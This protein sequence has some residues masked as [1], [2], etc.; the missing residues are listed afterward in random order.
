MTRKLK[1]SFM[2][3]G[4][5]LMFLVLG[6]RGWAQTVRL[7]LKKT[8]LSKVVAALQQQAPTVNFTFSQEVLE[9]VKVDHIQLK[10]GSLK[11]ALDVLEKQYGLHY[12]LDGTNLTLKYVPL[13]ATTEA[14]MAGGRKIDGFVADENGQ[15]VRAATVHLKG[16]QNAVVTDD[17]G[18]YS[19]TVMAGEHLEVS[20][21]G[22]GTQD[23]LVKGVSPLNIRMHQGR[24]ALNE[25]VFVGY[26]KM[27]KSDFTGAVASVKAS[28]LNVSAPTV[29]QG[30]VGKVAG[31]VVSQTDGSPYASPKIR[32]RGVNSFNAAT[33]PL[34]VIDGYPAGNDIYIN[35]GDIESI[36]IL[37]DA[38]SAAIYGSRASGGVV[39]ITTKRGKAGKGKLEY[40]YQYGV[41]QL[42]HK[43]KLLNAT[44]FAQLTIDGHNDSYK[45]LVQNAGLIWNDGMYS[46]DNATRV[47]RVGNASVVSIPT[48]LYDFPNQKVIT[49]KYNTDWQNE[50]YRNAPFM[51][52][53]LQFSGGSDNV[54]YMVS[55][56]Y[57]SQDGIMLNTSQQRVNFRANIDGDVNKKVKVGANISYTGNTNH[58]TQEG[59][60]DHSP[61]FGALIYMPVFPAYNPD[62]SI[63]QYLAASESAQYAYQSIENPIATA[64]MTQIKRQGNRAT[65]NGYATYEII[66]KLVFKA[67]LGL[68]TYN[69]KYDYYLPTSLSNGTNPPFSAQSIAAANAVAQT[70]NQKDQL[71]EFTLTYDRHFGPHALNFLAGYTAQ[72]TSSDQL[73]ITAKGFQNNLIPEVTA[74]TPG[75]ITMNGTG[76]NTY[77]LISYLA[78]AQYNYEGKYYLTGSFRTDG[79]S[80]FGAANKYAVF[81]SVSAGWTLSKEN[82]YRGWLEENTTLRLRA[83]WGLSGNNNIGNYNTVQTYNSPSGV[84]FGNNVI[85]Q[86]YLAGN[87]MDNNLEWESTS[88]YNVGLDLGM[89]HDR[90]QLIANYY[91]SRTYNLLV[92][93]N[94][95]AVSGSSSILTNLRNSRVMN[96]GIDL[97][98]DG[99]V[100][101]SPGGFNFNVSGNISINRN[102]VLN[103]G[104]ASTIISNGA[105]RQ[106]ITHITETG[107]PIGMYYG[108]KVAGMVRAKDT[109]GINADTKVYNANGQSFPKGYKLQGPPRSLSQTNP[110]R[111][112]DLYFK[113][114]NGDGV[115]NSNDLSIIGT[116]YPKFTYG[117][118]L[119]AS[120]KAVDAS[121][122]FA[123]SYGNQ[124]LDGQDYYLFNME[125]SGNQYQEVANRYRSESQPGDGHVYRASRAGTQ[126][127]STRLSTFYLQDGSFLRCTNVSIGY[128]LPDI[129]ALHRVGLSAIRVYAGVNNLFTIT[130]YKGYNPEVDYNYSVNGSTAS[131]LTPGVD[132]GE[133]PLVRA[134]NM[135]IHV[136]F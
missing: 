41:D 110:L 132:Y 93:N 125:G 119:S 62:G 123:G 114:V 131:N 57:Q 7:D 76:K 115:V 48:E 118:S 77:T 63:A 38:A 86:A 69:E 106:Y 95:S 24:D 122:S 55:G 20:S 36:D 116:P 56:G 104:G 74:G 78:R 60:W 61:A 4:L 73:G 1:R 108:Y 12:L 71:A 54:R 2:G 51:R 83:S 50:I 26:Q 88:Q 19:I 94:I 32:V 8:D 84:I 97:Q 14:P 124:V 3:C 80:R 35:P 28:E 46:D 91:D 101:Q 129:L 99:K 126:S 22:Y 96:R 66:P 82:F 136:T 10:S 47:A 100:I 16:T 98:V 15:P 21:I 68:Q 79:S 117:F 109:A 23:V 9:R 40:D 34:Y 75:Q 49:P 120:Y 5:L 27:R 70:I 133:Y 135:G 53:N 13:N 121:A 11:D 107:Q 52:H 128:N 81:P 18:H 87:V 59:R 65:Y 112:G 67:N 6:Q 43:V 37:K 33:D 45:D 90:I 130:R 42:A 113:D 92:Q 25:V 30:L 39:L 17:N 102:K 105:E 89:F 127:N 134:Y 64:E 85:S 72:Q 58:E 111:P 103:L 29:G 44:Q 31:V